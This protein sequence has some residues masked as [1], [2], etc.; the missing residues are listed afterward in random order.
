[1]ELW[2]SL[3]TI[4]SIVRELIAQPCISLP[5]PKSRAGKRSTDENAFE[6]AGI[7]AIY[8]FGDFAAYR[9]VTSV[10]AGGTCQTLIYIGKADLAGGRKGAL[11]L[12][13]STG[14]ALYNRLKDHATSIT[15]AAN[16][17]LEDFR[18]R[19][20][21]VDDI[22]ISL[23]ERR[24]I[25]TYLPLWNTLIDGFGNHDPGNRR[26]DQYRSDWDVVHPGRHW[27]EKLGQSPKMVEQILAAVL[28]PPPAEQLEIMAE[29]TL[30][31][32]DEQ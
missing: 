15:Q 14:Y 20:L 28:N 5:A 16:L 22:W 2:N 10:N 8:Y 21:V 29:H 4:R 9:H 13:S 32:E 18:C 25:R 26:K 12:D 7:Y 3:I 6:G 27:A 31:N 11:E 19:Y 30:E 23:G 24:A 1:L 17:R